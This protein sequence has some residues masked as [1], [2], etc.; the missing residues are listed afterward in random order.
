MIKFLAENNRK[1]LILFIHGFMGG[2]KT[3]LEPGVKKIPQ[4]LIDNPEISDHFDLASFTYF[5]LLSTKIERIKYV[6]GSIPFGKKRK[7]KKNLSIDDIK[8]V[9]FSHLK[10]EFEKYEK[11]ILVA[12]SMGGLISKATILK[13]KEEDRNKISL[14]ISLAVPHNGSKL[15]DFGR[16]FLKNPNVHDLAPLSDILDNVTRLWINADTASTLPKTLYF[17]GKNDNIVPNNS[18]LGYETR[19]SDIIYSDDDHFSILKPQNENT[20][21]ISAI[22]NSILKTLKNNY[23]EK[24]RLIQADI[25]PQSL[26][27]LTDKIGK[28]LGIDSFSIN[29]I[30]MENNFFPQLSGHLSRR[31]D[32][33]KN[34][35]KLNPYWLAIHGMY[36]T[37]K[38][39]LSV[40]IQEYLDYRT[41]WINFK[42]IEE[43]FFSIKLF[44]AFKVKDQNELEAQFSSLSTKIKSL[45]IL[46]DLPKLGVSDSVDRI[47]NDFI[48]CCRKNNIYVLSTSNHKLSNSILTVNEDFVFEI[49][50]PLLT[51]EEC[52][53]VLATYPKSEGFELKELIYDITE[54][55]PLYLQVVCRYLDKMDWEINQDELLS[56]F[57]GKLFT[58]LTDDTLIKFVSN[59]EDQK[60]R[61]LLYRLNIVRTV[62]TDKEIRVVSECDPQIE[63]PFEKVTTIMGIWLQR[64]RERFLVSPL[65]KRL[66]T[67]NVSEA[68]VRDINYELGLSILEKGMINQYEVIHVI[69][70]FKE[71]NR[72]ENAGFVILNLLKHCLSNPDYFYDFSLGLYT[73]YYQTIPAQMPLP[74][75]LL[76]RSLH[77]SLALARELENLEEIDFLRK[78]LIPLVDQALE[79]KVDVYFPSVI[80]SSSYLKENSSLALKYFSYYTNSYTYEQ[81]P[82]L[83]SVKIEEIEEFDQNIMWLL[84]LKIEDLT[85]LQQWFNQV[86]AWNRPINELD[87]DQAFII[88][89][90]LINNFI[91]KEQNSQSPNWI[92]LVKH[93]NLI[94]E[95]AT[96]LNLEFLRS[97]S[98]KMQIQVL[99]EKLDDILKAEEIF[100]QKK[101]LLNEPRSIFLITDELGRQFYY[102]GN[103]EK[104]KEYLLQVVDYELDKFLISKAETYLT[105]AKIT[106]A[107]S[108]EKAHSFMTHGLHFVS[109][110]IYINEISYIQFKGEFATSL[111]LL[112]KTDDAILNF[113]EGYELLLNTFEENNFYINTQIRYGNAIGYLSYLVKFGNPPG[114]GYTKPYRGFISNNNDL[115]DLYYPEKLLINVFNIIEY[116]EI[117]KDSEKAEYWADKMFSLKEKYE[118]KVFHRMLTPLTGYI[119]IKNQLEEVFELHLEIL[120]LTDKLIERDTSKI[121]NP[122]EKK[123]VASIQIRERQKRKDPDFDL[124]MLALN[125]IVIY[126]LTKLLK[127]EIEVFEFKKICRDLIDQYS[128]NFKN[129][130][131]LNELNYILNHFP[132]NEKES[133]DLSIYLHNINSEIVGHLQ[134][135]TYLIC[136]LQ[137]NSKTAI[138]THFLLAPT[139]Q[140]YTGSLNDCIIIPFLLKYWNTKLEMEPQA[141]RNP[142]KL[143]ENFQKIHKLKSVL[144]TKAIFALL[145]DDLRYELKDTDKLFLKEY[146]DEYGE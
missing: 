65:I 94:F 19:E 35:L 120:N 39:Q 138:A 89:E 82:E 24:K 85:A 124:I 109:E 108:A 7:F 101:H 47:F 71:A 107:S 133:K 119:I 9:L 140:L 102:K 128:E 141:F 104:A 29:K 97:L 73:W 41:T 136:S 42:D 113:I 31:S 22:K 92:G 58:D 46:D 61:D 87:N 135:L 63:R 11:I 56:F 60:T 145:A 114:D 21:V 117:I 116:F 30:A 8:D 139:F 43:K 23:D 81:L 132:T 95:K 2:E 78:D 28:K 112:G 88:S 4:Y 74:I 25:S 126:L 93:F 33:I 123:L 83:T 55:Y 137:M 59:V 27:E 76:I 68:L 98:L 1:H 50:M 5:S 84:L 17:Q 131:L 6:F 20:V 122:D 72:Y 77:L 142:D 91:T 80:L 86:E 15:A 96:K 48:L 66:G 106:G 34:L 75:R 130:E 36:G 144:Q 90:K 99:S 51:R 125:P 79:E 26:N 45:I 37:G 64:D 13:L 111:F 53:E 134:I 103:K 146:T 57:T 3:W 129:K 100:L 69:S 14:F 115:S 105:L 52:N 49:Q 12:H 121:A 38:T 118:L 110:N 40:L 70:Y 18:S 127:N 143:S 32:T 16:M 44:D 10:E 67:Q 62:I 54:G